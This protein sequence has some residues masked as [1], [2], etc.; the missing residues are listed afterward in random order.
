MRVSITLAV[1]TF[2]GLSWAGPLPHI[3]TLEA[4]ACSISQ[5]LTNLANAG[6][7]CAIAAIKKGRNTKNDLACVAAAGTLADD[8]DSCSDCVT[9][10]KPSSA[11]PPGAS[12]KTSDA[13]DQSTDVASNDTTDDTNADAS[14]P[15]TTDSNTD[16]ASGDDITDPATDVA[17]ADDTTDPNTDVASAD[18][19]ADPNTDVAFA[20]DT[21]DA[22]TDGSGDTDVADASDD[23]SGDSSF[24]VADNT[25]VADGSDGGDVGSDSDSADA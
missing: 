15:D 17:F 20:D 13:S 19:S 24:D 5:C 4:R 2:T 16:V 21:T 12:P 8:F 1:I 9:G 25:D 18:D 14:G 6:I 11:A 22:N 10:S 3:P 23:T 7:Q